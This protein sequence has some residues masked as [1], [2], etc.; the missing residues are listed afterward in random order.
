MGKRTPILVDILRLVLPFVVIGLGYWGMQALGEAKNPVRP[1]GHGE[2]EAIVKVDLVTAHN[3]EFDIVVDGGVVPFRQVDIP[4]EV[5]GQIVVKNPNC[6]AGRYVTEGMELFSIDSRD[7]ELEVTRLEQQ[8]AQQDAAIAETEVEIQNNLASVAL[9][10]EEVQSQQNE[11]ARYQ[12]L[13]TEGASAET[14]LQEQM[15]TERAARIQLQTLQNQ[16]LLLAAVRYRLETSR[17]LNEIQLE[18]AQLKLDRTRITVPA[19]LNGTIIEDNIEL[20]SYVREGDVLIRITDSSRAEVRCSLQI[21]QLYWLWTQDSTRA[22]AYQNPDLIHEAPQTEVTVSFSVAGST[23]EWDG[24]LSRYEGTGLDPRSRT[25]PCR[26]L[27]DNPR[28]SRRVSTST[29]SDP[30]PPPSLVTGMFVQISVHTKTEVPLVSLPERALRP[31]NRV[32]LVR[33]GQLAVEHVEV[34][35]VVGDEILLR[36]DSSPIRAGDHVV[37][38]PLSS[39]YPGMPV[40]EQLVSADEDEAA[41]DE[42]QSAQATLE[43]EESTAE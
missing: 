4:A 32:W 18:Q 31:G 26:V 35:Q 27:V 6:Q 17:G 13:V 43:A 2:H 25:V 7:F 40:A 15:R 5:E 36:E 39:P 16:G 42:I 12:G 10:E 37:V 30:I 28:G 41:I 23:Y 14:R 22:M 11:V 29:V 33:D 20:H 3:G 24:V 9:A 34:V 21:D 8:L 38:S 1:S 19:G